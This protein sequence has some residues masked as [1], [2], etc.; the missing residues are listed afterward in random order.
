MRPRTVQVPEAMEPLFAEAERVVGGFFRG[1]TRRPEE[2]TIEIAGDRYVLLRGASLSVE[3]FG[4]V[5]ELYGEGREIE[6]DDFARNIL[7]DLAHAVGR[8]DATK[9][10]ERVGPGD[11]L[12]RLSAGPVH[13][14]F[15]GWAK[16]DISP[17]STPAPD[18]SYFLLYDHPYSFES[19]AWLRSGRRADFPVCI[20]SSGYSA[21]WCSQSFGLPL[22]AT[23]ILCRARG[24]AACRFVMA[25][26]HRIEAH[27]ERYLAE[28]PQPHGASDVARRELPIPDLFARKRVE[29]ML[30]RTQAELEDRVRDRTAELELANSLLRKEIDERERIERQLRQSQKMEALG[31]LAGGIAHD[32]NNVLGVIL[33]ESSVLERRIRTEDPVV[34]SG[35]AEIARAARQAAEMTQQLLAVSRAQIHT[36]ERID[37]NELVREMGAM[38]R[39][40]V[41]DDVR[42]ITRLGDDVPSILG[43]VS[44]FRQVLLNLAVNA[45][46]AMPDGGTLTLT[47]GTERVRASDVRGLAPGDYVSLVVEDTGVGMDEA[48]RDR[49]FDPFFTTKPPGKGSGLGLSTVYGIVSQGGGAIDVESSPG[50]GARFRVVFPAH[51]PE[52]DTGLG[53]ERTTT[54]PPAPSRRG[55]VLVVED[56][57]ALRRVIERMLADNGFDVSEAR[58]G[59]DALDHVARAGMPDVLVTDVMMPELSGPVLAARLREQAPELPVV[60]M[61]GHADVDELRRGISDARSACLAKPFAER[62]LLMS[63]DALLSG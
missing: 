10:G 15:T 22:V 42:L 18:E 20:M 26:P 55:R 47:T 59:R 34:V 56:D 1:E 21:G 60:F 6:A 9:F 31:R 16:V 3:F 13:F 61:S 28:H 39:R 58:D 48:T 37:L 17:A 11:A 50:R 12:H 54:M 30:R 63:I 23:E 4:L 8:S 19:D 51:H 57:D 52:D 2:G 38:L 40:L 27:V 24:D 53:R 5:R 49:I 44:G 7:F 62:D 45:R 46:D 25:P 32:F 29:E 14:A 33:G 41:G 36:S 35:L 43:N